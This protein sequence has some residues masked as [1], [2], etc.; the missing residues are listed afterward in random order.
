[1]KRTLEMCQK[2]AL[3]YSSRIEWIKNDKN[4]YH[5][6]QRYGWLPKCTKHMKKYIKWN[7]LLCLKEAKKYNTISNWID[8]SN[9]SYNIARKNNWIK[10]CSKHMKKTR[11][12]WTKEKCINDAKKYKT[13]LE[14]RK[15]SRYAYQAAQRYGWIKECIKHM[16]PIHIGRS[17][18][19][20]FDYC[21]QDA[22]KYSTK[23][24]WR[25]ASKNIYHTAW[26]NN[27]L[28]KITNHMK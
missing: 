20:T 3:K 21:K 24:E 22:L 7:Y 27:W 13:N 16:T 5:S 1:M 18:I 14:W 2:E 12:I 10:D 26:R 11:L 8:K 23:K 4:S 25:E 19:Y 15:N 9:T 28:N 6:A 17:F